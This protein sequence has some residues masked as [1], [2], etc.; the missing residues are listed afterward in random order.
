MA[1][2]S[3]RNGSTQTA[4]EREL[5]EHLLRFASRSVVTLAEN[6]RNV[7]CPSC[8]AHLGF[9]SGVECLYLRGGGRT[10]DFANNDV[11]QTGS[12]SGKVRQNLI[13]IIPYDADNLMVAYYS[14]HRWPDRHKDATASC[15]CSIRLKVCAPN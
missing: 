4:R 3:V 7:A 13:A 6:E 14:S 1:R 11:H 8:A 2:F 5:Y 10:V 9:G 12:S 15:T